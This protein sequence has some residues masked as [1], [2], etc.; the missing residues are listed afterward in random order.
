MTLFEAYSKANSAAKV[1]G[2]TQPR[3]CKDFGDFWG[4]VFMP[5]T[6]DPDNIKTHIGGNGYITINKESGL[7][8]HFTPVVDLNLFR[9]GKPVPLDQFVEK[10][11]VA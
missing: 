4:F 1:Q 3:G 2:L 10:A 5:P 9:K 8:G 6:Y 11:A 7:L